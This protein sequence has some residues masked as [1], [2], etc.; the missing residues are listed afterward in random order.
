MSQT[1]D[2]PCLNFKEKL[3]R[4]KDEVTSTVESMEFYAMAYITDLENR[5]SALDADL[6]NE[7][8]LTKKLKGLL[9]AGLV[10]LVGELVGAI[11]NTRETVVLMAAYPGVTVPVKRTNDMYVSVIDRQVKA[12]LTKAKE[13]MP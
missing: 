1:F 5:V 3:E 7:K 6:E 11:E 8:D 10:E 9:D 13:S 12:V 2:V 4:H